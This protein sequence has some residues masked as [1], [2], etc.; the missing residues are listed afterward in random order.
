MRQQSPRSLVVLRD[1]RENLP[2]KFP[3]VIS[4]YENGR[5]VVVPV[6]TEKRTLVTADYTVEQIP[7]W[8]PAYGVGK[9]RLCLLEKKRG[10]QEVWQNICS[11]DSCRFRRMMGRLV[12]EAKRPL[13]LI[14]ADPLEFTKPTTYC[15]DP[16]KALVGLMKLCA[17]YR[18]GYMIV[19]EPTSVAG[20]LALG[21]MVLQWM[22]AETAAAWE[23]PKES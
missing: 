14:L 21:G 9:G 11:P 18:V 3:E 23:P 4:L 1:T 7:S 2:L 6:K 5:E 15:P 22:I 12:R 10:C 13:L 8:E 19:R 20:H 17:G 16:E